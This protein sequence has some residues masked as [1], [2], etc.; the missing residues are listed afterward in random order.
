[1]AWARARPQ[2]E[3]RRHGASDLSQI[4]L[5]PGSSLVWSPAT[6]WHVAY[7]HMEGHLV[8]VALPLG[9]GDDSA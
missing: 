5:I 4:L 3:P 8:N 1:M 7:H 6:C 9:S 2:T